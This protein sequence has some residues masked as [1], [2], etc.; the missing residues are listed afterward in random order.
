MKKYILLIFVLSLISCFVFGQNL[1]E[2]FE[3]TWDGGCQYN[4]DGTSSELFVI[5]YSMYNVDYYT[6]DDTFVASM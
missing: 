5:K 1:V 2:I 6:L 3:R 4:S